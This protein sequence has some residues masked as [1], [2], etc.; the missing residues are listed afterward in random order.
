MV[1]V[2]AGSANEGTNSHDDV[3]D[4]NRNAGDGGGDGYSNGDVLMVLMTVGYST[5]GGGGSHS[6]G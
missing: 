3:S 6:V 2:L 5:D 1:V 4:N